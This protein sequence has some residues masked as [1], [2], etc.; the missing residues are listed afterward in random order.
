MVNKPKQQGTAEETWLVN[1]FTNA[2]LRARRLA[3]GGS[4]DEGD[5][6]VFS[7][8]GERFVLESKAR[9]NLNIHQ[10]VGKAAAKTDDESVV[11]WKK[12]TRKKGK[13]RRTPDGPARIIAHELDSFTRL[14][15]GTPE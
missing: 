6:E 1:Y 5:V 8:N 15:G 3:E 10:T 13:E 2:G 9:A 12:L 7:T 4:N 14:I 11:S